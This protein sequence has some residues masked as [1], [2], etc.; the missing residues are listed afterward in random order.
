M[1]RG[2]DPC[3]NGFRISLAYGIHGL[4]IFLVTACAP[5]MRA[6]PVAPEQVTPQAPVT[7]LE[8]RPYD[9]VP[10]ESLLVVLVYRGG[11][12]A[13]L[14]HNHVVASHDLT[15][16]VFVPD[17]ITRASFEIHVPVE[18]LT[19]DEEDLRVP[20]GKEFPPGV[21][22]SAKMS[23]RQNMLG[24]AVLDVN[25][26]PEIVLES[27]HLE[28]DQNR[29]QAQVRVTLRDRVRLLIVPMQY[30]INKKELQVTGEITLR[31]TDFGIQPF[32]TLA[33]A[34]QVQ[35]ELLVKFSVLA[36]NQD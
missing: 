29:L 34:M 3:Y 17:D 12:L 4:A 8:G 20:E 1:I 31:Q 23:T 10:A 16:R 36:R 19:V 13:R 2:I 33:G 21:P 32:S 30:V 24:P 14:G 26:F 11:A 6:P 35:D 27:R 9:V 28:I 5:Y 15:G 18:K 7:E 22:E 25:H